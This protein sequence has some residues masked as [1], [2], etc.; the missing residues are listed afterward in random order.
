[1]EFDTGQ[2]FNLLA[3][4]ETVVVGFSLLFIGLFLLERKD[5][6]EAQEKQ[7]AAS[8]ET[9]EVLK[10]CTELMNRFHHD[11]TM[12]RDAIIKSTERSNQ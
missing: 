7:E 2:I 1:M 5:R 12:W 3:N 4:K 6:R 8:N 10:T 11:T 9:K